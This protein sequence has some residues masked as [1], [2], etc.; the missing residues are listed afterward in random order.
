MS[1]RNY[2][3][4]YIKHGFTSIEHKMEILPQCVVCLKTLCITAMKPGLLK[5]HMEKSIVI[6]I[7][8]K[9]VNIAFCRFLGVT[10]EMVRPRFVNALQS[11][12]QI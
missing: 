5:H 12:N 6:I 4:K 3:P 1:K 7:I 11:Y 2:D 8:V 10:F 9:F